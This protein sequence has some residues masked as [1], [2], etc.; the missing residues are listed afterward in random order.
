MQVVYEFL[1]FLI[2]TIALGPDK[3]R[4]RRVTR[5]STAIKPAYVLAAVAWICFVLWMS[6]LYNN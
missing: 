3:E 6:Y 2:S 1:F 4:K 5:N